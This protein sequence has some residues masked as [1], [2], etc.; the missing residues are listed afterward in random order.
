VRSFLASRGISLPL[1]SPDD[2][3]GADTI[4]G[5][6]NAKGELLKRLLAEQGPRAYEDSRRFLELTCDAHVHTAVHSS[7]T[8]MHE[9]L[10]RAGLASLVD[11]WIDG[12]AIVDRKL[13]A[14]PAPD[15]ILASCELLGVE[16]DHV[17]AF[18]TSVAGIAAARAAGCRLVVGIER[19]EHE[20]HAGALW[21]EGADLVVLGLGELVASSAYPGRNGT[22]VLRR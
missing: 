10:A 17:A 15:R 20:T 9:V 13:R 6:A 7:S 5:L 19:Q 16:P 21:A 14:R 2:P 18:E 4:H 1:G 11:A 3:R 8:H 12:A 22:A